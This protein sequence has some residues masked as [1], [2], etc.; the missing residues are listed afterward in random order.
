MSQWEGSWT[1]IASFLGVLYFWL[2]ANTLDAALF[3]PFP[4]SLL[5]L[6]L[7][8]LAPSQAL[9]ILMPQNRPAQRSHAHVAK[10]NA[11]NLRTAVELAALRE[12]ASFS[13]A[14]LERASRLELRPERLE[15]KVDELNKHLE[16]RG[17]F[18]LW[19][20]NA[21]PSSLT[22]RHVARIREQ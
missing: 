10:D 2:A 4:F 21:E 17:G 20:V 14:D 9:L 7:S 12:I 16:S 11:L 8:V 15:G 22:S 6:F 3:D 13:E 18:G 5:V 1:F 19:I